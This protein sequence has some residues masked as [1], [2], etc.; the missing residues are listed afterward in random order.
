MTVDRTRI[1]RQKIQEWLDL[2]PAGGATPS[3]NR[4]G[5]GVSAGQVAMNV[6]TESIHDLDMDTGMDITTSVKPTMELTFQETASD[7]VN[8]WLCDNARNLVKDAPTTWLRI[9]THIEENP[10]E[11]LAYQ[12]PATVQVTEGMGGDANMPS[13]GMATMRY[14]GNQ[15]KGT[16]EFKNGIPVFT[17]E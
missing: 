17:A 10:G 14:A 5:A 7:P 8:K 15:V 13:S 9:Y 16:V 3:W 12:I 2:R 11:Y 6:E 1:Y 4:I